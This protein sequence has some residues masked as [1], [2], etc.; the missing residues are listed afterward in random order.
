[1]SATSGD[2]GPKSSVPVRV[3]GLAFLLPAVVDGAALSPCITLGTE[4]K[5]ID[6][7]HGSR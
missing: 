6:K 2:G 3:F 4:S 1:M 7:W 5:G